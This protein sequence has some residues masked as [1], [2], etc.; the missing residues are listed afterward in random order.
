MYG[1]QVQAGAGSGAWITLAITI[2]SLGVFIWS[3][4]NGSKLIRP[5]DFL[6]LGLAILALIFWLY[7][8]QPVISIILLSTTEMLGFI[9]TVRKTWHQPHSETL[10]FYLITTFRHA[11]GIGALS[12]YTIVTWLY[13]LTWTIANLLFAVLLIIRRSSIKRKPE[14]Q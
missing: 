5:T 1:L 11:L 8:K 4:K 12:K 7:A 3:L 9:P 13:P 10:S 2:V 14:V 6:F